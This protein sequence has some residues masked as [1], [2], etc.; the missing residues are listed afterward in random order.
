MRLRHRPSRRARGD[1]V[2]QDGHLRETEI[3]GTQF[4]LL[5]ALSSLGPCNQ[6]AIGERFALDKTTL[7]RNLKLL[8]NKGWIEAAE[9]RK[10]GGSG[11]T[12]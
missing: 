9:P 11:G 5:S 2:V 8:K 7:S 6:A 4:A 12:S 10:T 3:E 1:A